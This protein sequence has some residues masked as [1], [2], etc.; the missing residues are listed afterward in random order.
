MEGEE[1]EEY[2]EPQYF[3]WQVNPTIRQNQLSPPCKPIYDPKHWQ[4]QT[5]TPKPRKMFK[6]D[7]APEPKSVTNQDVDK[8]IED[9]VTQNKL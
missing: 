6:R 5:H 2:E 3:R 4:S 8:M 9:E 1:E 7:Q